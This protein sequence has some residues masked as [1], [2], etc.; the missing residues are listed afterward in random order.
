[1]NERFTLADLRRWEDHGA[2]WR[3]VEIDERF[4]V[5]Q[6]CTCFGEPVELVRGEDRDLI[7]FVTG[8]RSS[9]A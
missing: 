6:L 4:A 9:E 1:M 7:A 5:V 8:R 2:A 3:A